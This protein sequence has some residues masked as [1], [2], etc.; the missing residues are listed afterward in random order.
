MPIQKNE[1]NTNGVFPK[2]N[3]ETKVLKLESEPGR[4][5]CGFGVCVCN[6]SI[7]SEEG[8]TFETPALKLFTVANLH[9][10]LTQLRKPKYLVLF[11]IIWFWD[12]KLSISMFWQVITCTWAPNC[13]AAPQGFRQQ[14]NSDLI[15]AEFIRCVR[16]DSTAVTG[17]PYI[18]INFSFEK[19]ALYEIISANWYF[20]FPQ[21]TFL[22]QNVMNFN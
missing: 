5:D 18:Y 17:N 16:R 1:K 10:K 7:L 9:Y 11:R 14:Q 20:S 12:G 19:F 4:S 8:L 2:L 21:W 3:R 13:N 22:L 15:F 6:S